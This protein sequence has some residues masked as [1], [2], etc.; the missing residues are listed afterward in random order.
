MFIDMPLTVIQPDGC[1]SWPGS[2]IVYENQA[3]TA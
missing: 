3:L 1:F 2:A